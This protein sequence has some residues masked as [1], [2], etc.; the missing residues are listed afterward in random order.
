MDAEHS[1]WRARLDEFREKLAAGDSI[2]GGVAVSAISAALAASV[3]RMVLVATARKQNSGQIQLLIEGARDVAEVLARLADEDRAAYAA[4][5]AARKL[6]KGTAAE[7]AERDQSLAAALERATKT[8]LEAAH[9]AMR[10]IE[11]CWEAACIAAGDIAADVGGA[12]ALL[13]GAIR[14][15]LVSVDANLRHLKGQPAYLVLAAQRDELEQKASQQ[16]DQVLKRIAS[17]FP[18]E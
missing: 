6:P 17:R 13:A 3:L 11:L 8:P 2:T 12:A 4:Y 15:I 5:D 9:A 16:V 7:R 18:N 1:V 10:A 14:A